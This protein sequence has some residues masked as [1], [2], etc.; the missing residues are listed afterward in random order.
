MDAW[1]IGQLVQA[2]DWFG[3]EVRGF[4]RKV[5]ADFVWLEVANER[6]LPGPV[7]KVDAALVY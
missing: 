6:G 2:Q 7:V 5:S 4:V 3:N 1:E